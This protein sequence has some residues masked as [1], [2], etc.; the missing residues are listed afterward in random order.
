MFV[1]EEIV[2]DGMVVYIG[3]GIVEKDC[4]EVLSL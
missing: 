1:E 4:G 2:G 3:R